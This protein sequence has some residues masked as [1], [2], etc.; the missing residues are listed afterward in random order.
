[1]RFR[2]PSL[3]LALALPPLALSGPGCADANEAARLVRV[4]E[5]VGYWAVRGR[6]AEGNNYIRP[7]ARFRVRNENAEPISYI[8]VMAVF[9]RESSPEEQWG[10]G[11]LHSV[12]EEALD[13][14]TATEELTLRADSNYLSKGA[15]ERMFENALWEDVE[16]EM[17][18]RVPGSDWVSHGR[19]VAL[20]RLG[21]PGVEKYLEPIEDE[22]IYGEEPEEP[23]K[24]PV[25][26]SEPAATG[27]GSGPA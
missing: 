27:R 2:L 14:G 9:R 7:A 20:R 19:T 11:Y 4:T 13:P 17:F 1:M 5:L 22:P 8:R 18:V 23:P 12:S 6:D 21:P 10:E 3:A 16:I 26:P 15:P 25:E 24:E